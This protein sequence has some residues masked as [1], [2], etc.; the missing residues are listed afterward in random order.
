MPESCSAWKKAELVQ[1]WTT[2][3][4]FRHW[5]KLPERRSAAFH[6]NYSTD[7][8]RQHPLLY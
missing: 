2:G 6:L 8:I 7:N 1:V 4:A 5:K 3:T